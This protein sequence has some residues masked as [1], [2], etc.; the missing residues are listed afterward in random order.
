MTDAPESPRSAF[1][2]RLFV[3]AFAVA[4]VTDLIL[5]LVLKVKSISL[6]TWI[7]T[8]AHPTL[9]FA[10]AIGGCYVCFLVRDHWREVAFAG[11]MTGHLFAHY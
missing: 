2:A 5:V 6:A 10:G 7:A 11:M 4:I 8:E 3:W 1:Y 9:I